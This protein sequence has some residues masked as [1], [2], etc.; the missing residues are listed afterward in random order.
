MLESGRHQCLSLVPPSDLSASLLTTIG[1]DNK[2]TMCLTCVE[3]T[4]QPLPDGTCSDDSAIL[5]T[6]RALNHTSCIN[7][8]R[9][10]RHRTPGRMRLRKQVAASNSPV[11]HRWES[12]SLAKVECADKLLREEHHLRIR[13]HGSPDMFSL[14]LKQV[15]SQ[16]AH[17]SQT[18][19]RYPESPAAIRGRVADA[20]LAGQRYGRHTSWFKK[21]RAEEQ[22]PKY[23][24]ASN[25]AFA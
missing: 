3:L 9:N 7:C 24:R 15:T 5:S 2:Q 21:Q 12:V 25:L 23:K 22:R 16:L 20:V 8:T 6:T 11:S 1:L 19:K 14:D 17:K 10:Q 13:Q 18:A 4:T